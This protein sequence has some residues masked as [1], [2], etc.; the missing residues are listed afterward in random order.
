MQISTS[1]GVVQATCIL[2]GCTDDRLHYFRPIEQTIG[3]GN[4]SV[5]VHD[6]TD[7]EADASPAKIPEPIGRK[8]RIAHR[9][10]DVAMPEV[11]LQRDAGIG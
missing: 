1:V 2:L 11:G 10:L 3:S 6:R 4:S 7:G 5:G 8:L 9:M